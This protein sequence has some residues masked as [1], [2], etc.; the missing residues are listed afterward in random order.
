MKAR[1]GDFIETL[2]GL[3]FDVK[4]LVHPRERVVAYLRYLED[5]SGDRVRAGK[6]YVKVY[7]L[8]RREAILRE[9]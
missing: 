4:G 3:I 2:E 7:S 9:R 5:P 8:E 1:E 6:R